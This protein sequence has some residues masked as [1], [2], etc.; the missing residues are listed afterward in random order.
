MNAFPAF[1][2]TKCGAAVADV[3]FGDG[4]DLAEGLSL[5]GDVELA[6]YATQD[7]DGAVQR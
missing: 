6:L 3:V 7:V 2:H 4:K 5:G 1:Y